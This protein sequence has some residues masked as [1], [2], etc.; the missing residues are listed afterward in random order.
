[1][2]PKIT[3]GV[4]SFLAIIDRWLII[5]EGPL[6]VSQISPVLKTTPIPLDVLHTTSSSGIPTQPTTDPTA[7]ERFFEPTMFSELFPHIRSHLGRGDLSRL[8]QVEGV[9][10]VQAIVTMY[11][12]KKLKVAY[13]SLKN[14]RE[15]P[16]VIM[17]GFGEVVK[18]RISKK[19]AMT[20]I[21]E[22]DLY[23]STS[24][25][26][27][28]LLDIQ[29]HHLQRLTIRPCYLHGIMIISHARDNGLGIPV[30]DLQDPNTPFDFA[31]ARLIGHLASYASTV[32]IFAPG[33]NVED[34]SYGRWS[35]DWTT[36]A[37]RLCGLDNAYSE[38]SMGSEMVHPS[39]QSIL[40]IRKVPDLGE[41]LSLNRL[42][43]IDNLIVWV[44]SPSV[45]LQR[46]PAK[47]TIINLEEGALYKPRHVQ[48]PGKIPDLAVIRSIL[49]TRAVTPSSIVIKILP[50]A[51]SVIVDYIR[52]V[53][54]DT[55]KDMRGLS[56]YTG[57][58]NYSLSPDFRA[59]LQVFRLQRTPAES[60]NLPV[61]ALAWYL[62]SVKNTLC[63]HHAKTDAEKEDFEQV[64]FAYRRPEPWEGTS[65]E[66]M[67]F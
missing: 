13:E 47:K 44:R 55:V 46:I 5:Q 58:F 67:A 32:E 26:A 7:Y 24:T 36:F 29:F 15:H 8:A 31:E 56:S 53:Y 17:H 39:L 25:M 37:K 43:P 33:T 48:N 6:D 20:N 28:N 63:N 34:L 14:F 30:T 51:H 38:H 23:E 52:A 45:I 2:V 42:Q 40:A 62:E 1:M 4:S 11:R 50:P 35:G 18:G 19:E 12:E 61:V 66:L 21:R 22:I 3:T 60:R 54:P 64:Q 16:E 9:I 41:I 27:I 59:V 65:Y 10:G 57:W 49:K